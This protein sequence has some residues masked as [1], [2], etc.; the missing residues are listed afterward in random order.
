MVD[1]YPKELEA[2]D[3]WRDFHTHAHSSIIHNCQSDSSIH[4]EMNELT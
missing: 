1:L 4:L 2:K 3:L